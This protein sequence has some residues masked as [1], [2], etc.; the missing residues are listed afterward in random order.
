MASMET[1]KEITMPTS[2]IPSSG[3]E[4]PPPS[5]RKIRIFT[6]LRPA[7]PNRQEKGKL[8]GYKTGAAKEHSA[9]D[10]SAGPGGAG[11]QR[12][13]LAYADQQSHLVGQFR[14]LFYLGL[15]VPAFQNQ[16]QNA[17]K[18]QRGGN[19]IG[20]GKDAVNDVVEQNSND[21]GGNAGHKH[22]PH[23]EK[24]FFFSR[25]VLRRK[26]FSL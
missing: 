12:Q 3:P 10:S 16:E 17:V 25:S 9:E 26:G 22:L 20:S 2:K 18:N 13:H 21:A 1:I 8:S 7:S 4:K 24:V 14:K 5:T 19:D 11:N 15:F 23:R 6:P